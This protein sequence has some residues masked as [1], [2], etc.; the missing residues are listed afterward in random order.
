[1]VAFAQ[2]AARLGFRYVEINYVIP[3]QGVEQLLASDLV[4]IASLHSPTPRIKTHDGR[5]SEALNLASLDQDERALA[6]QRAQVT[7]D[8]AARADTSYVVVHLGG[9]GDNMYDE[10]HQLR[11]LY[12]QGVRHGDEVELLRRQAL[13]RRR[14][15]TRRH[16]PEAR[17]SLAKIAEYATRHG[18]AV[19]LE[20]RYHYHEFPSIDEMHELLAD[21]LPDLVGYWHDVGH[22]EVLDRLGLIDKQ[23]WLKELGERCLGA[24]VHDVDGLAD[25][26][27][28]G[29]GTADW[30]HIAR[31]LPHHVPRVFEINQKTPEEEFAASTG[32]LRARGLL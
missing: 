29:H 5:W 3:P 26:R 18:I 19:G 13:L 10:E 17:R 8:Y 16:F 31:Y 2:T 14:E 21:Y 1:M 20:N 4:S 24:H 11:R 9:M 30:D 22:A 32:F 27:P 23:R 6:V 28:P 15:G 7:I 25:H 12:D